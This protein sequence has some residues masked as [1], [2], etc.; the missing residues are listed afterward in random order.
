MLI[1]KRNLEI[2]NFARAESVTSDTK[3]VVQTIEVQT[4]RDACLNRKHLFK[5]EARLD[6]WP[7]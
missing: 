7:S 1:Y 2:K 4:Q 6:V 5:S 3:E